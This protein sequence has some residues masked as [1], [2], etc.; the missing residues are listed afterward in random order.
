MVFMTKVSGGEPNL[1][2]Y[3]LKTVLSGSMEPDIQTGSMI[4]VKPGGDM[5]R[6]TEGDVI[7]FKENNDTLITHRIVEVI[8]SGENTL[9]RTK[10]DN[11]N[12]VDIEPVLSDNVVAHYTGFTVPYV[13]YI[14]SFAQS[15]NGAF[16]LIIPGILLVAYSGWTIWR[17]LANLELPQTDQPET[18]TK[19]Q[20]EESTEKA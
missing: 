20:H 19:K 13:G 14:T 7:T 4:A 16:L 3:Q 9:Y 12:G 1:F 8:Q 17:S 15:K 18:P 10:G 2:G 11:N 5:T 6:F